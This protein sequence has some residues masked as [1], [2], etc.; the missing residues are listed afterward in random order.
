MNYLVIGGSSG[1]GVALVK[2]LAEAGNQVWCASRQKGEIPESVNF[3]EL[4]VTAD[5][6]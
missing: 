2:K 5:E 3:I 4:D 1:I 6:N